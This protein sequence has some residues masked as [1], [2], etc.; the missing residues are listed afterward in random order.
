MNHRLLN[1]CSNSCKKI[2]YLIKLS[3]KYKSLPNY[4]KYFLKNAMQL[5]LWLFND[6]VF[7][8]RHIYNPASVMLFIGYCSSLMMMMVWLT[9]ERRLALIPAGTILRD[10]HHRESPTVEWLLERCCATR[11]QSNAWISVSIKD[12]IVVRW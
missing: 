6:V 8:S 1:L 2:H 10:P 3:F 9:E 7:F 4:F 5:F 11:K 12:G